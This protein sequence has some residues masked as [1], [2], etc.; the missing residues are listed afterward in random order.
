MKDTE[1]M[2]TEMYKV[3]EADYKQNHIFT[4]E[5]VVNK[6]KDASLLIHAN[7]DSCIQDIKEE[8]LK[9]V[10][11]ILEEKEFLNEKDK[12]L[13]EK[14][15]KGIK[16]ACWACQYVLDE[17]SKGYCNTT[18]PLLVQNGG[19]LKISCCFEHSSY[20][21]LKTALNEHDYQKALELAIEIKDAWREIK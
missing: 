13:L 7:E 5:F 17:N 16:N 2:I 15:N 1:K 10:K 19:S 12:W 21:L 11:A 8:Y 20:I 3:T 4:W 14:I 9:K 6:I 18:C